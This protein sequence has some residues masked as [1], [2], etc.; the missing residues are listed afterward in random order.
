MCENA[1]ST[2]KQVKSQTEIEWQTKHQA[3]VF[4][5]LPLIHW[6]C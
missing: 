2:V 1:F 5:F 3:T 4:D 6:Y